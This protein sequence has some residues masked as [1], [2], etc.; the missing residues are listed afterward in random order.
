MTVSVTRDIDTCLAI[1]KA[2]FTDEQGIAEA[3][4]ADGLD[5]VAV[6][7]LLHDD[8]IAIGT[9]RLLID[10]EAGKI[11]RVAVLK[12]HRGRGHGQALVAAA[13]AEARRRGLSRVKLGSRADTTDFYGR[14]GFAPE[15]PIFDDVGIPHQMMVHSL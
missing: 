15:G 6:L 10:G 11:G 7:F 14:L 12:D 3:D 1:R 4:D 8:D 5:E 9:A 13:V 2:V